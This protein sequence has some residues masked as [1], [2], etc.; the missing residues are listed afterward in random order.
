MMKR[1]CTVGIILFQLGTILAQE[2]AQ[3]SGQILDVKTGKGIAGIHI[4]ISEQEE[5]SE[6][7]WSPYSAVSALDGSYTIGNLDS[8]YYFIHASAIGYSAVTS[9]LN[10]SPGELRSLNLKMEESLI[11]LGEVSVTALH[12]ERMM[13]NVPLP[14]SVINTTRIDQQSWTAV[15]DILASQPGVSL[16]RDGIWASSVNI[17]GLSEQ[18]LVTLVDGNR[19][20]TAT[21]VAG[22]LSMVDVN[23]IERIEIVKGAASAIYG[24]GA[25]GGIINIHTREGEYSSSLYLKGRSSVAWNSVNNQPVAGLSLNAGSAKWYMKI[26]GN[27]RQ[28]ENTQTPSGELLNSQFKDDNLSA[29][30]AVRPAVNKEFK[31]DYHRFHAWDVGLPGGK[32]FP[33]TATARYTRADRNM[34][35]AS[36]T[37]WNLL[38]SLTKLQARYYIQNIVREVD[39]HPNQS[40]AIQPIGEHLTNGLQLQSD[41][42]PI[43]NHQLIAGVDVWQRFLTTSREKTVLVKVN[44]S[45]TNTKVFGEV[46]IPAS[47]FTNFGVYV[48]DEWNVIPGKLKL[49]AGARGDNVSIQSEQAI[50]PSYVILNGVRNDSPVGQRITFEAAH[51]NDFSWSANAGVLYTLPGGPDL[52]FSVARGQRSP[53]LEERFKYIDLGA[54]VRL[55]NPSLKPEQGW[56]YDLGIRFWNSSFNLVLDG[57]ANY[58][59]NLIVEDSGIFVYNYTADETLFDTVPALINANVAKALLYGSDLS[60]NWICMENLVFS[61]NLGLVFGMDRKNE[62]PLPQIPPMNGSLTLRYTI[63][64]W[65]TV[66]ATSRFA[67]RQDRIAAGESSTGGYAIYDAGFHTPPIGWKKLKIE[68]SEGI[69]NIFN[70]SYRLHLA[71]NRGIIR[72]E[73]GRNIYIRM[74][75]LF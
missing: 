64:G 52:S 61:G 73:P 50:D 69:E 5:I 57:Y 42:E 27:Y 8:G 53:S 1:F 20:E 62:K 40:V 3:V 71:T 15:S 58:M 25:M 29:V 38:P 44:D 31:I 9:E 33:A 68:F 11:P 75:V 34:I 13:K 21:D 18:R 54:S 36:Y 46:P 72:D 48:Q 14:I 51:E 59:S 22:A 32:A 60:F 4:W 56:F 70:R 30:L 6:G 24:T 35:S 49:L 43:Y 7:A 23:D 2:K 74:N 41:W 10:I 12:T 37:G 16:A 39:L 67:S 47:S 26:S 66:F 19:I 55:G 63:P 17:R 45:I 28:A 65:T